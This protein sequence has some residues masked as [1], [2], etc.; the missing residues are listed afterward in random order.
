MFFE[1]TN[2]PGGLIEKKCFFKEVL[3]QTLLS[4]RTLY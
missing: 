1:Q 4:H 2:F 3:E